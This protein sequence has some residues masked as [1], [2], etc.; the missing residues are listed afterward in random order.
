MITAGGD[1]EASLLLFEDLWK[2]QKMKVE[3]E[4]VVAVPS[5][6]MLL[7]TGTKNS[8]GVAK[9]KK[10]A[11]KIVS[12]APYRLTSDLFVYRAGKFEKYS[13]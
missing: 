4:Y 6:D 7:I 5:R 8:E 3:G 9:L 10:L 12:E 13:E 1:Y 11:A 2:E